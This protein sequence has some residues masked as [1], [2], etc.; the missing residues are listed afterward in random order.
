MKKILLIAVVAVFTLNNVQAQLPNGSVAP[1]FTLTD[2]DGTSHN[3]YSLLDNGYT[4]F[5]DFSAIWCPPCWGYHTSGA[6]EDLYMNHGPAGMPNVNANTTDDVMVFFIEGDGGSLAELQGG[7]NSQGDWITGTPYPILPTYSGS[8]PAQ[9]TQDYQIGYW[10]TVYQ[11]CPDRIVSECGQ[12]ASPYSL[13]SA[14]PAP[15]SNDNDARTFDYAGETL[16]CEGDL[17]PEIMIQ[18]Y[19]LVN[20]TS[21]SV[22]VLVNGNVI[23]TTPWTGN[24]ATYATDNITLPALTGLA[25]NDAVSINTSYPNGVMDADPSNNPA[26]SFNVQTAIQNTHVDVTVQIV[27]DA[28][29]SE[30]TWDITDANG[31]VVLSGGPYSNLG[32]AGTTTETPVSGTL[33]AQICHTFTIYD[34]YGDGIDAGYGVGSFTVT[35]GN[36][37]VLSS[38]GQFSDVDGAAFK[39]GDATV[40]V[41]DIISNISIYPNPVKDVLTIEGNYTSIEVLDILGNLVLSSKAT[42]NINVSSLADGVYMLNI[43][44]ENG[45]AA[46]KITIAK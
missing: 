46:K 11:I 13:V 33:N 14:C 8:N 37:T 15:A 31:A 30:T 19:G 41:N 4:V 7:G 5:I 6:L 2:L 40:G 9:V 44:T 34:T 45:I 29:G 22:D 16:T 42:K 18:N 28:Y 25:S 38:G 39:T 35:D 27:T 36:G 32:A 43:K 21:L 1:D 20:L 12:A 3:L 10:P 24:L 17:V 23:S 26:A